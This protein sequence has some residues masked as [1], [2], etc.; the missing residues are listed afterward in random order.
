MTS[1]FKRET[2]AVLEE[3]DAQ[4]DVT[5]TSSCERRPPTLDEYTVALQYL[6]ARETTTARP[7]VTD[8]KPKWTTPKTWS[9]GD[10][11]DDVPTT[12]PRDMITSTVSGRYYAGQ[13]SYYFG[14]VAPVLDDFESVEITSARHINSV[15]GVRSVVAY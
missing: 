2:E 14:D 8:V 4:S 6:R 13:A 10:I 9:V 11:R 7:V 15:C 12:H 3:L 5:R 1:L